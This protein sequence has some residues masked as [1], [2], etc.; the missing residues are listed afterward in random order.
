LDDKGKVE[1][2]SISCMFNPHEYTLSKQN[3]WAS[4]PQRNKDVPKVS[5][6]T[7]G[8]QILKLTLYF[9]S[10]LEPDRDV[11]KYTDRLWEMMMVVSVPNQKED[12]RKGTPPQVA[13]KWGSFYFR[14]VLTS[15]TQ[16]FTLF[17]EDGMP[18][19]CQ[20]DV[21]LEQK[22]DVDDYAAPDEAS[23]ADLPPLVTARA[24]DRLD[25]MAAELGPPPS[26]MRQLAEASNIDNPLNIP[27]GTRLR[28]R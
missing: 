17:T 7:G 15:M 2:D 8:S 22:I 10:S 18:V 28:G 19:R 11:R 16:K 4:Q 13:F 9:D 21:T 14:A 1:K 20:V 6:V 25:N 27:S 24:G 12:T 26:A 23:A 3:Q 5:F